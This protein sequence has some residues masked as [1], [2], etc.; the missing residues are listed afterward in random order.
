MRAAGL[1]GE[2]YTLTKSVTTTDKF[3]AKK[4]TWVEVMKIHAERVKMSGRISE[5]DG[6][7]FPAYSAEYNI[8]YPIHVEE[9][10]R[11]Q[12]VSGGNLYEI[13]NIIPNWDRQMKTLVCD[14]VNE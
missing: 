13:T 8:R 7:R 3:G 4:Q 11:I 12:A 2:L 5:E 1:R 10:W 14:R 9:H 6:E